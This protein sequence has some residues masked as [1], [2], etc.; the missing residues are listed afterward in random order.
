MSLGVA[1]SSAFIRFF[2][3]I[4]KGAEEARSYE[5]AGFL[6]VLVVVLVLD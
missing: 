1:I 3:Q 6:I 2:F 4:V 5:N